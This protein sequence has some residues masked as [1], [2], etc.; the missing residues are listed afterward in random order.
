MRCLVVGCGSIGSRRARLLA[1]MGHEVGCVDKNEHRAKAVASMIGGVHYTQEH[2]FFWDAAFVCTPPDI[3]PYFVVDF[4][5]GGGLAVPALFVEKPLALRW[6][7]GVGAIVSMTDSS[8]TMGACNLRFDA[9]LETVDLWDA[10]RVIFWMGQHRKYWNPDHVPLSLILDSIHELDLAHHFRGPIASAD[11]YSHHDYATV[12]VTHADG[13]ESYI[14][15]DRY[16]DP[17]TRFVQVAGSTERVDLWP[18]D[19]EMYVREMKHF[20]ACV[21]KGEQTCNPLPQA[22]ETLRWAL[23]IN[24]REERAGAQAEGRA[25]Q[26]T[27]HDGHADGRAGLPRAQEAHGS[28]TYL[29]HR[30][31]AI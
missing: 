10:D 18:P 14:H 17:P 11:G 26:E 25:T 20:L 13:R 6:D 15:L 1:E 28:P 19:G 5:H 3:T 30:G 8:V 12:A 31:D 23:E 24:A 27:A 21:E 7:D 22:A 2:S 9:R 29:A 4:L 16:A